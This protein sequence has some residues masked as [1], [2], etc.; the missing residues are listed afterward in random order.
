M[1]QLSPH[2]AQRKGNHRMDSEV[3][4]VKFSQYQFKKKQK[5]ASLIISVIILMLAFETEIICCL[6]RMKKE[7]KDDEKHL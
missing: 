6:I 5:T 2:I 4:I 7:Y 1:N 3:D